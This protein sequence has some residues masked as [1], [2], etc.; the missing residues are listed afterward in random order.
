MP[1]AEPLQPGPVRL[2]LTA[3]FE[4]PVTVALKSWVPLVGTAAVVG[5][6]LAKTEIT[7]T[8]VTIAE[9]DFVG[10]AKLV[11]FT[12]TISGEGTITGGA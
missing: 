9:A 4:V 3:V 12:V 1:H 10:S 2:Q 7:A 11:A 6:M 8:I 5:L